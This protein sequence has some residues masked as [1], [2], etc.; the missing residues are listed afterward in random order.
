MNSGGDASWLVV[1]AD[2]AAEEATDF[3]WDNHL[4]AEAQKCVNKLTVDQLESEVFMGEVA[5]YRLASQPLGLTDEKR[6]LFAAL[7]EEARKAAIDT[8]KTEATVPT[9]A[10]EEDLDDFDTSALYL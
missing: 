1:A 6:E 2:D 9:A 4:A 3:D 7:L 8:R 5:R 10:V